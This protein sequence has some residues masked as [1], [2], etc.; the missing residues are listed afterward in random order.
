MPWAMSYL[1]PS[2][3][4]FVPYWPPNTQDIADQL[5]GSD[6]N[7]LVENYW[8]KPSNPSDPGPWTWQNY[9][10]Y[11]YDPKVLGAFSARRVQM[12][13]EDLVN[14]PPFGTVKVNTPTDHPH[15]IGTINVHMG[16]TQIYLSPRLPLWKAKQ[17]L[18]RGQTIDISPDDR[19]WIRRQ[20][21]MTPILVA[22]PDNPWGPRVRR[23][24]PQW[25][26][27]SEPLTAD[28]VRSFI[29]DDMR[30]V[31]TQ[32]AEER[33]KRWDKHPQRH[34]QSKDLFS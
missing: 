4:Y 19:K 24:A 25:L 20:F 18:N 14:Y 1:L 13:P 9:W 8:R 7:N 33:R 26:Q 16:P 31:S 27:H 21:A 34:T 3:K 12:W 6:P 28:E 11:D 30:H 2:D 15:S 5:P 23:V 10:Q 32:I 22:P 29:T 17:A